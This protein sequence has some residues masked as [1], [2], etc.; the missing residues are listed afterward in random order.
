MKERRHWTRMELVIAFY[1][2]C[3][4]PYGHIHSRNSAIIELAKKLGRT[5]NALAMKMCNF[6]SFDPVHKQRNVKGL[7]NASKV[8]EQIWNDFNNDWQKLLQAY[9]IAI[10]ELQFGPVSEQTAPTHT[11]GHQKKTETYKQVKIRI[12]QSFFRSSVLANYN[13]QC[14]ICRINN[15][16][17]LNAGHII[18]WS[19]DESYRA[20][21]RNGLSL[22]V[23]HDRAFDRG[24][25]TLDK[26]LQL[27]L[28]REL[29]KMHT[30]RRNSV[31]QAAFIELEGRRILLPEKFSPLPEALEYHRDN[32][33]ELR[34]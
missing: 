18:P 15:H 9:Q 32:I 11:A 1:Q 21:P 30:E 14:A 34:D 7:T 3:I 29:K 10:Q 5:P 33:F 17:L 8:D 13:S 4:T 19:D 25:I 16:K 6:A 26:D 20:D 12:A 24:M 22:C 27:V 2:Y 31:Y 28:S 23:L